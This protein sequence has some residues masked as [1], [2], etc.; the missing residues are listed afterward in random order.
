MGVWVM[1]THTNSEHSASIQ[2]ETGALRDH[3]ALFFPDRGYI[4]PLGLL[5]NFRKNCDSNMPVNKNQIFL[6]LI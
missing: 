4:S 2:P 1:V 5:L 3:Q 6:W